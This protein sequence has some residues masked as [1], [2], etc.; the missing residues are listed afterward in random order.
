MP[1]EQRTPRLVE[2]TLGDTEAAIERIFSAFAEVDAL[3]VNVFEKDPASHRAIMS[4]MVLRSDLGLCSSSSIRMRLRMLGINYRLVNDHFD[5]IAICTAEPK[6]ARRDAQGRG[7]E[8]PIADLGRA[9]AE[10]ASKSRPR[11]PDNE[12]HSN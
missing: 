9:P 5:P 6:T 2:Q 7:S 3:E 11:W 8:W 10:L 12:R 4:G 1:E